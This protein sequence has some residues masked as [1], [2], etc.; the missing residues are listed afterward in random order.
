MAE[1]LGIDPDSP[2]LS[3]TTV[4]D[5]ASARRVSKRSVRRTTMLQTELEKSLSSFAVSI[6][7]IWQQTSLVL[8]V[9]SNFRKARG[10]E[11]FAL[12]RT[13]RKT[14]FTPWITLQPG[15]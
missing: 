12:P 5:P 7:Q 2:T 14:W 9:N 3:F 4:S 10:D 1:S 13:S 8:T 6:F 15:K 11:V